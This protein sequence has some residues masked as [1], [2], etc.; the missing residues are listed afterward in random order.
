MTYLSHYHDDGACW[1]AHAVLAYLRATIG[2]DKVTNEDG[3]DY[4]I[5]V[6]RYENGREQ[7]YVLSVNIFGLMGG[8]IGK[9]WAFYEHR[10][11]DQISVISHEGCVLD[12]PSVE[13]MM[14][15]RGKY[16]TD[17][18]FP[19]GEIVHAGGYISAEILAWIDEML[20]D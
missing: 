2:D 17:K 7:G 10:N 20:T 13:Q 18:D 4:S 5:R 11:S 3:T 15:G 1:Q 8:P 16:D 14:E 12:T 9:S 19:Y 6:G